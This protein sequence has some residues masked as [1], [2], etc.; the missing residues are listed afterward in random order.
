MI[1]GITSMMGWTEAIG[2]AS[3]ALAVASNALTW[4]MLAPILNTLRSDPPPADPPS[5]LGSE[6]GSDSDGLPR[7]WADDV[8]AEEEMKTRKTQGAAAHSFDVCTY[9]DEEDER[10]ADDELSRRISRSMRSP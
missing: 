4:Y 9:W 2:W 5:D 10:Q 3:V 6:P 7:V 8:L 1:M